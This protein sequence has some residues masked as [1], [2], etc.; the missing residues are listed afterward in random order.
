MDESNSSLWGLWNLNS[1]HMS[2]HSGGAGGGN[3]SVTPF[4]EK[5]LGRISIT[6]EG[7]LSAMVTS[8]EGA[9]PRTGTEWPLATEADIVRSAR[10]MVAYCGVCRTWKEG[11]TMFLAT[12]IEL[13]LDPN[14]IGTDRVRVAE[15][16]EEGG[17]TFLTLK[18]LQE[19]TTEDGT[20]GDLTICWEKVQ[21]PR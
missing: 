5:P 11:E 7:Y 13:A 18:P 19:F 14:M 16:R 1:C 2:V 10:P 4:G 21:L 6:R 8:V 9:A 15:V 20:K 3:S 12:K 17:R